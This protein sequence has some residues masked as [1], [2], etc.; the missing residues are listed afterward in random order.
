MWYFYD[1]LIAILIAAII[2][3]IACVIVNRIK[4]MPQK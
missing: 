2:A 1:N 4:N 3:G